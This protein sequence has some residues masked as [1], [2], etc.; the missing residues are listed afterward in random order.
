MTD[1]LWTTP[2]RDDP[3]F[4]L[5]ME[6]AALE[7]AADGVP[8]LLTCSWPETV[9]VIGYGQDPAQGIDL[10][11][12]RKRGIGILRRISGGTGVLHTGDLN[13]SL[14]LPVSH[15]WAGD[16]RRLYDRFVE[17]MARSLAQAEV[18]VERP[19][20]AVSQKAAERSPICFEDQLTETLLWDGRK[21]LG[22]AQ[23][24]R[25]DSVLVHG[26]LLTAFDPALQATVYGVPQDRI[27]AAMA[28]LP[29]DPAARESLPRRL[30]E[31]FASELRLGLAPVEPG[32][33]LLSR[34]EALRAARAA[35]P[36][37]T[38]L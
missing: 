37:R 15:P 9:L 31:I 24:R 26:T 33:A 4:G 22:C 35:D 19:T 36:R 14:A 13:V 8:R 30:A 20:N 18:S 17:V 7:A 38:I 25:K 2:P 21:V 16:I 29:L 32:P 3:A 34:A 23:C 1:L 12:C 6:E 5:A 28:E 10:D 27:E 11:A